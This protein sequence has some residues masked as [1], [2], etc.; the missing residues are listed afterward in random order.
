MNSL[1][2]KYN[3]AGPRYTSYPTVP[4]WDNSTF[5]E[6]E[7]ID[8][9]QT[10]FELTNGDLGISLYIHLPYCESLCTFC[11]CYKRITKNHSVEKPYILAILKEWELYLSF[12]SEK[13]TISEIHLGGGTPSFFSPDMLE[14]L[15][16][17]IVKRSKINLIYE[18]SF[19][20]HPNNTT[21]E[22]LQSL[23]DYGFKR[24]SFGVQDYDPIVQKAINR[25]QPFENVKQV[26]SWS[27]DIGYQSV[28]HD[29]VYGL[30]FQKLSSIEETI[31]KTIKLQPD[32]ISLYSYAHVPWLKGNG[33][34]GFKD[35]NL[36]TASEK[37]ALYELGKNLFEKNNYT[38]IGMDHFALKSDSLYKAMQDGTLNRNFM[39]Y[40]TTQSKLV[41]GL[42]AS[43]I[44]DSWT[45]FAQNVKDINHYISCL[46]N[47]ELPILKG[48]ILSH[49]DLIMR[50]HILNIICKFS[51][52]W[53]DSD[54]NFE[55]KIELIKK[56]ENF[57]RDGLIEF[58]ENSL[59]VKKRGQPFI[60]NICMAFDKRMSKQKQ[61]KN[62]FSQTI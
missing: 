45:G 43:A 14:L 11:G 31:S 40:T 32:R 23:Y 50:Q 4:F 1:I 60:R 28:S 2:N 55:E 5:N 41:L 49:E 39:G 24:V 34:R 3:V 9:I 47:N 16:N 56:L 6:K 38:E 8:S 12:L 13:P 59:I 54:F 20:G 25:I 37:R 22:H 33:Q 7:W 26:I 46:K 36:P 53:Q 57:E 48:H 52:A 61:E 15:I 62:L 29:L 51:T 21:R 17:G 42:G 58:A 18:F 27:R 30:P 35:E 44:S 10:T 19:E